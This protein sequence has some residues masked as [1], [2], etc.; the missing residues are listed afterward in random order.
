MGTRLKPYLFGFIFLKDDNAQ[1]RNGERGKKIL[2]TVI[3]SKCVVCDLR[4][5]AIYKAGTQVLLREGRKTNL[6]Q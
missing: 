4:I 3:T 6:Q 2:I 1:T 5:S